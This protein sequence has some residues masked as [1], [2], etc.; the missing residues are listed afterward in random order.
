MEMR[1]EGLDELADLVEDMEISE[2]KERK[3]LTRGGLILQ[4]AIRKA[5]VKDTG[6]SKR[7]VKMQ[8]KRVN[9]DMACVIKVNKWQYTF[10]EWGTSSNKKN[11]G[12]VERAINSASTKAVEVMKEFIT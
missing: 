7:S 1:F 4:E 2:A 8:I 6:A 11:V 9:G 12:K 3:A 10:Q 5:V